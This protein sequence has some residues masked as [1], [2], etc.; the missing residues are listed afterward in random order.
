MPDIT[1]AGGVEK[2]VA[3]LASCL[4]ESANYKI[5]IL[6][7]IPIHQPLFYEVSA[8]VSFYTLN[9]SAYPKGILA[10]I[11]WY[12]S[13][14]KPLDQLISTNQFDIVFSQGSYL[15]A[16]LALT[17]NKK[18]VKIG[19]EHISYPSV[20]LLHRLFRKQWYK[21][22]TALVVLTQYDYAYFSSFL[23]NVYVIPN[24]IIAAEESSNNYKHQNKTIIAS[25]RLVHQKGFDLLIKAFAQLGNEFSDWKLVIYGEGKQRKELEQLINKSALNNRVKLPGMVA[26]LTDKLKNASIF[27]SSSRYEGLPLVTL[28][29]M[30]LGLLCISSDISGSNEIIQHQVNG[31]LFKS[32]DVTALATAISGLINRLDISGEIGLKAQQTASQYHITAVLMKWKE[33]IEAYIGDQKL[34]EV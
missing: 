29:A 12:R 34:Y 26:D 4:S 9:R 16:C 2:V 19:C 25:G 20:H 32:E 23:S 31:I 22:L 14:I 13:L 7:C 33:L 10:R 3:N 11:N 15:N 6:T 8:K 21:H 24:F 1:T 17:K 27:V 30:S 28:E 18:I 5:A